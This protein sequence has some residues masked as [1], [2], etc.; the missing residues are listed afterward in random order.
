MQRSQSKIL[1]TI[2]NSPWHL[3]YHNL[4]TDLNIPYVRDVFHERINKHYNKLEAHPNP[5]LE[6]L[7]QPTNTRRLKGCW[8]L[9]LLGTWGDIAG[10][11]P[12][13]VIVIYGIVA[14][15]YNHHLSL[16]IVFVLIANKSIYVH[17][18]LSYTFAIIIFIFP[19]LFLV[20]S[21]A[22]ETIMG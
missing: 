2:A 17:T 21:V 11:I 8:L 16:Y 14:Y 6:P 18:T 5:L 10:W 4:H 3:T 9:D 20:Y 7:L 12:Y 13:H 22:K 19:R 1:R 15:L